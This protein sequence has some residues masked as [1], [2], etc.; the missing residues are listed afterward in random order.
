MKDRD[1]MHLEIGRTLTDLWNRRQI[2][3][4]RRQHGLLCWW[5]HELARHVLRREL[6]RAAKLGRLLTE[7]G[8]R[9][10]GVAAWEIAH[11]EAALRGCDTEAP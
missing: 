6:G 4:D 7:A 9:A 8:W 1:L 11:Y 3:Q 10:A 5:C 2:E